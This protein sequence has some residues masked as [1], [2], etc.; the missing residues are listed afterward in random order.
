M[1]DDIKDWLTF[2]AL[3]GVGCALAHRLLDLFDTPAAVLK[4]GKAVSD[5]EG[6]GRQLAALF[7]DQGRIDQA[8][9][10][11]DQEYERARAQKIH[12]LC[13]DDFLFPSLLRTIQDPPVLLYLR[14]K[15]DCLN[16]PAVAV[17]GSRAATDYGR[18]VSSML[19]GQLARVGIVVVSGLAM[20]ID[21]HAHAGCIEACGE[22]IAVLGCGVDVLYPRSHGALYNQVMEN[23]LLVSEYPLGSRPEGFRFPARNRI[24]SGL[25][26][27]VI[28]VEATRKSGSLITARLAL[29]QGRE[30]F[31][32]PGRIDSGKSEG[33]HR[34]LQ[35]GAHLVQSADDVLEELQLA[36]SM[37]QVKSA[38]EVE[39]PPQQLSGP[40]EKLLAC[41]DVY[42]ADIDELAGKSGIVP[43][44]LQ[45]LLLRL[46][47][48]GYIRQLPGQQ[49][50]RVDG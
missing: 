39:V 7:T 38:P 27:G 48:K 10:W 9:L 47:L 3:P 50:E 22:T 1:R 13:A 18:R 5:V 33:V 45:D 41:I 42:P 12:I 21:G 28:V 20:G 17:I 36:V 23:G 15:I 4:A 8:R 24:I 30:V 26:L 6:A 16:K 46:E 35:Q 49:Y 2:L 44:S 19:A 40:E 31:G 32:V 11:A 43:G 29:D 14:G 25:S 37:H 34:L